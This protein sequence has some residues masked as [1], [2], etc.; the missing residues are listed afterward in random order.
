MLVSSVWF[1]WGDILK[2]SLLLVVDTDGKNVT[3]NNKT[4]GTLVHERE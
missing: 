2:P 3:D 4:K 1:G